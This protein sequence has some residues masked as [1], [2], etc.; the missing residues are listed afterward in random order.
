VRACGQ[1]GRHYALVRP[2]A[3]L[4]KM[5]WR[6]NSA[7]PPSTVT[8]NR[9][10][11]VVVSAQASLSDLKL[12]P[13]SEIVASVLSK[14]LV[15]RASLSSL[16]TTRVSPSLSAAMAFAS[17][18]LSVYAPD[19]LTVDLRSASLMQCLCLRLQALAVS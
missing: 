17:R 11:G 5:R 6:S 4:D 3:V 18:G 7:S 14:S 1:S 15:D 19:A 13:R 2:S 12:A 10:C 9:P 8:I 16:H